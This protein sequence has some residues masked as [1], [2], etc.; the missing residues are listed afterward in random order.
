MPK[1]AY[2]IKL[3]KKRSDLI[4][5]NWLSINALKTMAIIFN[6]HLT[7]KIL[8]MTLNNHNIRWSKNVKYLGIYLNESLIFTTHIKEIIKN[9]TRV[10]GMLYPVINRRSPVRY[11]RMGTSYFSHKLVKTGVSKI[12]PFARYLAL[13]SASRTIRF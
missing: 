13:L 12:S 8:Q 11:P 2:N 1:F 10:R 7:N 3:T 4:S 6:Q 5:G 9:I